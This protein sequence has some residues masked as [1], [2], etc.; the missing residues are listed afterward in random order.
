MHDEAAFLQAMQE[1]PE[2]ASLRLVLADWLEERGDLRGELLRLLH[3]LTQAVEVP[4]RHGLEDRLRSLLASGVQPFGPLWTNSIGM[5]FAWI[6]AGVFLMGSPETEKRRGDLETQ[7]KAT[8]TKGFYLAIHPV[9]QAC[10]QE[11]LGN[12]PSQ[13]Q[14]DSLPVEEVSWDDSQEFLRKLSERDGHPH[15]LPTEAEWE[16]ACRAGT[17]TPFCFGD[18]ISTDQ[19]NYDGRFPYGKGEKGVYRGRTTVV[20]RFS[21]NAWGLHDMQGNV[22]EWCADWFAYFPQAEVVDPKGPHSGNHRVLRGGSFSHSASVLRSA[23]RYN[24]APIYRANDTGFRPAR[25]YP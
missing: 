25:T 15:R 17:T 2:D 21:S 12:N 4:D 13:F 24:F 10:W 16:Y 8:I 6:P 18:T 7:H 14:G 22:W 20:N 11:V 9:T 23:V 19:A 5:K 1:H 3:M